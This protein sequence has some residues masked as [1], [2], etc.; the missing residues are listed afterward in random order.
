MLLMTLKALWGR[1]WGYALLA[2]ALVASLVALRQSGKSAGRDEVENE[3]RKRDVRAIREA[4][5]V[6]RKVDQLDDD[7]LSDE[8]D[9]L[10]NARRRR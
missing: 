10:R 4:A 3:I 8:F 5:N 6:A 9:R 1:I 7:S 2:G